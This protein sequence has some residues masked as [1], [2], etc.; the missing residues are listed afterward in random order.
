MESPKGK[1]GRVGAKGGETE[2]E[3]GVEKDEVIAVA[4]AAR[5]AEGKGAE[6]GR[7]VRA[8]GPSAGQST[9]I[10]ML[11]LALDIKHPNRKPEGAGSFQEEM[12]TYMPGAHRLLVSHFRDG[13]KRCGSIREYVKN[14]GDG[15]PK[16]T[17]AFDEAVAAMEALRHF[18]LGVATKY[19]VRTQKVRARAWAQGR[20]RGRG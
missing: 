10:M 14:K 2:V 1:R 11:D 13:L 4:E 7:F 5:A 20:G 3:A 12:L 19:L 9:M 17:A 6:R 18:H 16:L 15:S 8:K